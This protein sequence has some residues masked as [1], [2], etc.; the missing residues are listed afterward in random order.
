MLRTAFESAEAAASSGG[1]RRACGRLGRRIIESI[2]RGC[3]RFAIDVI[4]TGFLER[5]EID[6]A[7]L[8][9]ESLGIESHDWFI[10]HGRYLA[11][12]VPGDD[13]C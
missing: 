7:T 11:M 6:L 12:M 8:R 3:S 10:I 1:R 9:F 2:A 5:S 13:R 4:V